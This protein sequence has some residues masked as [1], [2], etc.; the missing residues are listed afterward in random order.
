MQR[1]MQYKHKQRRCWIGQGY[2]FEPAAAT[3][4]GF[5]NERTLTVPSEGTVRVA[6]ILRRHISC[7]R[8]VLPLSSAV[9]C[10]RP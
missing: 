5:W 8:D 3:P 7:M 1:A 10:S 6:H 4:D 9:H 2:K